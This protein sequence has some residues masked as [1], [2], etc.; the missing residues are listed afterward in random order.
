MNARYLYLLCIIDVLS[1][2]CQIKDSE[3]R[4]PSSEFEPVLATGPIWR[5]QLLE[6]MSLRMSIFKRDWLVRFRPDSSRIGPEPGQFWLTTHATILTSIIRI[7]DNQVQAYHTELAF[8]KRTDSVL[9]RFQARTAPEPG[10][11]WLGEACLQ[12]I[13]YISEGLHGVCLWT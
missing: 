1:N 7:K 12:W 9:V 11:F 3:F 10:K 8:S 4:V 13:C 2:C 5:T 6:S